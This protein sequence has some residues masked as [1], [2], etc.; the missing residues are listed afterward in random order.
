MTG[1]GACTRGVGRPDAEPA[2]G[3]LD[4][5]RRDERLLPAASALPEP[6]RMQ[7][8]RRGRSRSRV[9]A[10]RHTSHCAANPQ[11]AIAAVEPHRPA[12]VSASPCV[13]QPHRRHI[14]RPIFPDGSAALSL[15]EPLRR[16][17]S[18]LAQRRPSTAPMR[19]TL[20]EHVVLSMNTMAAWHAHSS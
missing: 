10:L 17:I 6:A 14:R 19:W 16:R 12:R 1:E 4:L 18:S 2:R 8:G 11:R 9:P 5:S 13:A 20:E 3:T 7:C 15:C